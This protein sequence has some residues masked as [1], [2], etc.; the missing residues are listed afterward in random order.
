MKKHFKIIKK[1]DFS[2][3]FRTYLEDELYLL[4]FNVCAR[5][6]NNVSSNLEEIFKNISLEEIKD[7]YSNYDYEP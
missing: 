5:L 3:Y 7:F 4:E 2:E 1:Y 6:N